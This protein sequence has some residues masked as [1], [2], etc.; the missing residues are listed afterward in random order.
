MIMPTVFDSKK[1]EVGK[2]EFPKQFNEEVRPDIIARAVLS[3]QSKNRQPY[4]A[5]PDAGMR[6]SARISRRRHKYRGAYG[7]GISRVPRKIMSSRGT[8]FNWTGAIAPGT[9]GGRRA[10]PPKAEKIW[11]QKINKKERRKAIRSCLAATIKPEFVKER[12]HK[13]PEVYP[14]ILADNIENLEKT[15][16]A[17]SMFETFGLKEELARCEEKTIRAGKGKARNRKYKKKTG[18]LVVV[19]GECNLMK[20]AVN[21]PGVD[22]I[23]VNKL[24]AELLAPGTHPGRLTLFT[25]KSLDIMEKEKLFI[26]EKK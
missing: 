2:R 23:I 24:N 15:K 3:L 17:K 10:H 26:G 9:V 14:F 12:G 18:P 5:K 7:H 25:K 11:D 8:R 16:D 22:V 4:G 19:S 20:A 1:Q 6:A 13:V 21:I